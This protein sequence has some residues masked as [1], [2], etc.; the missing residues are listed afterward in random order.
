MTKAWEKPKLVVLVRIRPEEAVLS[1][2]KAVT[3]SLSGPS[4]S[5]GGCGVYG[6]PGD[7]KPCS[8][9]SGS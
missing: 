5:G 3:S 9:P 2:C 7:P 1:W 6:W 8:A 4:L